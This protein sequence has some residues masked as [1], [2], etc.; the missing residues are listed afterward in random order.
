MNSDR[1]LTSNAV[2]CNGGH[3][4]PTATSTDKST[5]T[6]VVSY[7]MYIA[8]RHFGM[9]DKSCVSLPWNMVLEI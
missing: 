7:I 9:D 3:F 1:N 5:E 2:D 6:V 4:E 8:I